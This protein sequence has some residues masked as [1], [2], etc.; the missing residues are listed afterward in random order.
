MYKTTVRSA[1]DTTS[2]VRAGSRIRF[3][4]MVRNDGKYDN[5]V[6]PNIPILSECRTRGNSLKILNRRCHYDLRKYSF[7]Q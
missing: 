7:L 3:T 2:R 1:V 5:V 4:G 6:T